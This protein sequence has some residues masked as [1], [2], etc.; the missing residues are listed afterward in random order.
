VTAVWVGGKG[1]RVHFLALW[2][3]KGETEVMIPSDLQK[4]IVRIQIVDLDAVSLVS[5]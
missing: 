3:E 2:Y 4:W 5:T 1:G